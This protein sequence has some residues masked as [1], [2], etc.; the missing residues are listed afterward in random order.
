MEEIWKDIQGYEWLYKVSNLGK[1]KSLDRERMTRNQYGAVSTRIVK[2]KELVPFP[3][4]TGYLEVS[5]YANKE[6]RN[7][8]IHRLVAQTFI[9]NIKE[10]LEVNHI[11]G[12]KSNNRVDNLEWCTNVE[13]QQH[14]IR[15]GLRKVKR[16]C[17]YD[18]NKELI[19]I[20]NN[21]YE[22]SR[23]MS[24]AQESINRCCNQKAKTA[25]GYI[26]KYKEN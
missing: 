25:G 15:N 24:I 9:P 14:A 18:L 23:E 20:W 21:Q 8:L 19:K 5:L 6:R 4:L 16:V 1:V 7:F 12:N 2:G 10:L 3:T 11:D 13:N 17:Q 26:W 22:A